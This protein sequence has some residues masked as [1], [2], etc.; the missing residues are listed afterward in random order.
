MEGEEE[1]RREDRNGG[2][3][4]EGRKKG[5]RIEMEGEEEK[6]KEV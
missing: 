5:E 3:E 1:G 2:G 6:R 4:E